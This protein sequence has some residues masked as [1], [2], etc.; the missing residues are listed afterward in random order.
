MALSSPGIGSN[1]DVNSIV[2]QLMQIEQRP[3]TVLASKEAG[4]QQ[5]ISALGSLKGAISGLQTAG[6]NLVPASGTTAAAKFTVFNTSVADTT[7]A[8]ATASTGAV[9]GTY[10]LE[11]TQLAQQHQLATS[12]TVTPFSGV[13]GTLVTG[14][15]LTI[16]LDT[17]AGSGSPSKT[18]DVTIADGSTPEAVRDAINAA[19][20]GVSATVVN[21]TAGKQLVLVGDTPGDNQFI[22]LS[23]VAALA[24]DPSA[25]PAPLTDA[26]VQSQAAQGS[27]FK[28]NGISVTAS[29]NTVSTAIEG[30]TLT[31]AKTNIG[32]PTKLIVTRDTSSLSAG[33]TAFVKAFNDFSKTAVS[34]GRY[35]AATKQ[36]GPL[37]GDSTLRSI[38]NTFRN[39]AGNI[40]S[41]LSGASLQRL[42]D[43]GVTMQK[44]GTLVVD[45]AKLSTAISSN[46]T[47]VANL[48]SA[49]GGAF[50]TAADGMVGTDGLIAARTVGLNASIKS[51]GKQSE[52]I[53]QRLILTE[54][55]Y[56]KQFSSLDTLIASM[57]T[58]SNFLSQQLAN[59]PGAGN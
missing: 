8:S 1:L 59:L 31:L 16:T 2:S 39:L 14:G 43:I 58:T 34:L 19:N 54:A 3:L 4:F 45:S 15:T 33:V 57:T 23:G 18:T 24:Y 49:Y 40:P 51:L 36:G 10:S 41:E 13:G 32:S 35:D 30:I 42:S 7:I 48:V 21:G 29:S 44:D 9:P 38:Q 6:S 26:F 22:K 20:A 25:V 37:I 55:R 53:Q 12:T 27:T 46:F 47:G 28:L 50:K 11:V 17:Q 52:A 5:K 56:R